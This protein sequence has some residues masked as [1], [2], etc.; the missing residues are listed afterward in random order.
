MTVTVMAANAQESTGQFEDPVFLQVGD[1]PMN[2]DGSMMYPSPALMDVDNDG[3]NELVIGTIFGQVFAC[4][5]TGE[6][7]QDPVWSA[8]TAVNTVN[9]EPLKLNNW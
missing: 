6:D 8:P 4:E 2:E 7:G 1:A 9:G 5:N 3:D